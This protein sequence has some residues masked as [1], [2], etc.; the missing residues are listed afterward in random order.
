MK[1]VWLIGLLFFCA[2]TMYMPKNI[3]ARNIVVRYLDSVNKGDK[4]DYL[5]FSDLLSFDGK[6]MDR[7]SQLLYKSDKHYKTMS[8]SEKAAFRAMMKRI[9]RYEI[10]CTYSVKK[11]VH[12]DLFRIDT[13][14]TQ[15]KQVV[16]IN[17]LPQTKI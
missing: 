11:M 15:I 7:Q 3:R 9:E 8:D 6:Y 10:I 12:T 17:K 4:V 13:T 2:C 5:K 16:N 14:F 1:I